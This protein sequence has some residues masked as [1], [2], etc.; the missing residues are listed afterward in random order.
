[1]LQLVQGREAVG[2]DL[3]SIAAELQSYGTEI[4]FIGGLITIAS[5]FRGCAGFTIHYRLVSKSGISIIRTAMID[6]NIT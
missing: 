5:L 4:V 2:Y 3:G 1:M 6:L